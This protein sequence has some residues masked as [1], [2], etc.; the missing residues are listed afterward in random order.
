MH[1]VMLT[2]ASGG[3]N[4]KVLDVL[5]LLAAAAV[6]AVVSRRVHLPTI[7]GYLII[8]ALIGPHAAKLVQTDEGIKEIGDLAI[9]L[10]MFTIGMHMDLDGIRSGMVRILSVG[11]LSTVGVVAVGVPVGMAFGL[12]A[13]VA[14][15]VAMALSM[16]ST[17]VALGVLNQRREMHLLH[18][19]LA[20][21]IE[22]VQDLLSVAMLGALPAIAAWAGAQGVGL[23]DH[24]SELHSTGL[25]ETVTLLSNG[26]L[27]F[28]GLGVFLAFARYVLPRALKEA[29]QGGGAE[30]LLVVSAAVALGAAGLTWYLGFGPVLG[31]FLAGFMLASTPF[32]YQ[33]A[34]QL[35]PLRDLF[36]AVFFTSVGMSMDLMQVAQNWWIILLGL[37]ALLVLK[38]SIIGFTTWACGATAGV[39]AAVAFLLGQAGEF[40]LVVVQ[41]AG[42]QKILSD[43]VS[44]VVIA[45]T[46]LSLV[47][48]TPW[49]DLTKRIVP[50]LQKVPTAKWIAKHTLRDHLNLGS[51]KAATS[52][53]IAKS[54]LPGS[55]GVAGERVRHESVGATNAGTN[56]TAEPLPGVHAGAPVTGGGVH[57]QTDLRKH[58][59][60]AGF[61]VVGRN[62]AEHF[63]AASIPYTVVEL[64]S[65]TVKKQASLGR[66]TV[67]GDVANPDVLEEAG[68]H[69]AEAVILTIPD[70]EATLR[71]CQAVRASS[72]DVFIAARTSYLSK[73]IAA[74]ELGADYVT[75]EEVVTAQDMAKH[76]MNRLSK[77][78]AAK[79]APVSP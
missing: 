62:I 24:A 55:G 12:S 38:T 37:G 54:V 9:I 1:E 17:A 43:K 49:Y 45:I 59:I 56:G 76:V 73:A 40:S 52:A 26:L 34:G 67:Y 22:L 42:N 18:G 6:V 64:N 8:G 78:V 72:P 39:S 35:S 69:H 25:T 21:G 66:K 13:P 32:R 65:V 10:L 48:A 61:G 41:E 71:A 4:Q 57:G 14:L 68:I 3:P 5:Y 11:V 44:G 23:D 47:V 19:R 30:Q 60:I 51:A 74:T 46:V 70:D 2:L 15:T 63:A 77:R 20:V 58:V 29:S 27:K 7:P 36:M 33:L 28:G 53:E 31:A 50:R 16:S 75:V 79:A